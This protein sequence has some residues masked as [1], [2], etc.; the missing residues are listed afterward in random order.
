MKRLVPWTIKEVNYL[1]YL[2]NKKKLSPNKIY[3]GCYF[4]GRT[5]RSIAGQMV[6]LK[7]G[8]PR[9]RARL[10]ESQRLSNEKRRNL[11]DFLRGPGRY[12]PNSEVAP[13]FKITCEMSWYYRR[14]L[15]LSLK[16]KEAFTSEK[17]RKTRKIW[18]E[19][20]NAGLVKYRERRSKY[21][22]S[23]LIELFRKLAESQCTSP[24]KRCK[25]CGEFWFNTETFFYRAR[26]L[27]NG[28]LRLYNY[29]KVCGLPW[30]KKKETD[31]KVIAA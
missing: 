26:V 16:K 19:A 12:M 20:M 24:L 1:R 21:H 28:K 9:V 13:L 11:F 8:N 6:Y 15:G 17:F 5:L 10:V 18:L 30:E 3:K 27:T 22:R 7:L 31:P 2:V 25:S 14:R 23:E 4:L 29:C